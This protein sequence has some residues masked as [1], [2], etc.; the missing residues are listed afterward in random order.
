MPR[1]LE[2]HPDAA[3][4]AREARQWYAERSLIAARAFLTELIAV[5]RTVT[6]DPDRWPRYLAGT[7]R[8][9]FPQFPFSLV[10]RV[11]EAKIIVVAIAHHRRRPGYWAKRK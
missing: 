5:M 2:F 9:F 1:S 7:R 3:V 10:Y 4:E 11:T 6:D 8:Y